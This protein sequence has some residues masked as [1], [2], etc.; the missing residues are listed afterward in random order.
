MCRSRVGEGVSRPAAR[1]RTDA[2]VAP[3]RDA[4]GRALLLHEFV[5]R[6]APSPVGVREAIEGRARWKPELG[7]ACG[8]NFARRLFVAPAVR[9]E[10]RLPK[11]DH[12]RA[13]IGR[14]W[15]TRGS[16]ARPRGMWP[17]IGGA[18]HPTC[19]GTRRGLSSACLRAAG[20]NGRC[21]PS[22]S[23]CLQWRGATWRDA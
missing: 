16:P 1:H 12:H 22:R 6:A 9:T 18:A 23:P 2:D 14:D 10:A 17:N 4:L 21:M 3:Y 7:V 19:R 11:Q 15:P 13:D 20:C 5:V 8:Q